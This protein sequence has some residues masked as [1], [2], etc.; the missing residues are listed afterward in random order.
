MFSQ[1]HLP[2]NPVQKIEIV[3]H[4]GFGAARFEIIIT[5]DDDLQNPPKRFPLY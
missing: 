3:I 5:M 1:Y 4:S 2:E